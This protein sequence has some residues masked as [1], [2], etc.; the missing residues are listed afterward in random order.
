MGKTINIIRGTREESYEDF[1][2]RIAET[3]KAIADL[4]PEAM[5]YTITEEKPPALSVIPFCKDKIALI[6]VYGQVDHQEAVSSEKG[7]AGSFQVT[8]V[9]PRAYKKDWENGQPTPGVC[10]L[11]LFRQKKGIDYDVFIDRWHNGHTPFTLKVHPIYHY[12]RNEVNGRTGNPAVDYDGIVEEHCR[13]M[14]TLLN[15]FIFF[16][17]PWM[18]PVN[19][20]RTYFDV[21]SFIDYKSIESYLVREYVMVDENV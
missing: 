12:N 10:L 11:T 16:G 5:H 4:K 19:M 14:K 17:K 1:H 21:N 20:V 13:D 2:R 8:E 9:L 6:S 7:Y 18:A 15:P 3:V